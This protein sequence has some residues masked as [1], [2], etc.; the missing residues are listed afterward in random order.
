MT[1]TVVGAGVIGLTSAIRLR[2]AGFAADIVT[3]HEPARTVASAVAGAIW[4]P[5]GGSGDTREAAWGRRSREVFEDGVRSG[6]PGLRVRRMV[7]LTM[8]GSQDPW[9][10]DPSRGFRRCRA[11]ELRAGY[12]D[13]YAQQTVAIDTIP[14]LGHLEERFAALGGTITVRRVESLSELADALVVN[15]AGVGAG[16]LCGDGGVH[17]IRGQ[18]VR[19]RSDA[20][21]SITM[22]DEG[23]L[24]YSYVMP[25]DGEVVV[26]GTRD[27]GA[28]DREPDGAVTDRLLEKAALLEPALAGAPVVDI[29]VG[30]RPGRAAV[31]LE[32]EDSGAGIV[33]NYGHAGNGWSLSWGCAEDVVRIAQAVV[34]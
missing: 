16:E 31:R 12:V 5:Y 6:E 19:L 3:E 29:K 8:P 15:A 30:L 14:H 13:G 9:W 11:E 10:A 25:H 23:P 33:H 21:S 24:A 28:W 7:E 17:P 32:Y 26:G 18:V 27:V 4:Y 2:E 1:V 20:V 34:G 22:V